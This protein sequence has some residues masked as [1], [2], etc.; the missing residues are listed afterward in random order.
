MPE[1]GFEQRVGEDG[2]SFGVLE[3][4]DDIYNSRNVRFP[5]S[6][7]LVSLADGIRV[8]QRTYR[9]RE[10]KRLVVVSD[11]NN[12]KAG[13]V[14]PGRAWRKKRP[15]NVHEINRSMSTMSIGSQQTRRTREHSGQLF[16]HRALFFLFPLSLLRPILTASTLQFA[17]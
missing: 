13:D 4:L 7:P 6:P 15:S 10:S 2:F 1:L 3:S 9:V 16:V 11:I 12:S 17:T 5:P 8:S 14:D